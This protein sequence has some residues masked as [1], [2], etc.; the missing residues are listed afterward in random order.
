MI[1]ARANR[2]SMTRNVKVRAKTSKIKPKRQSA[3]Q[4]VRAQ[5]QKEILSP[6][7]FKGQNVRP[8]GRPLDIPNFYIQVFICMHSLLLINESHHG[9][10]HCILSSHVWQDLDFSPAYN[11]SVPPSICQYSELQPQNKTKQGR[12]LRN[13]SVRTNW[14]IWD[15]SEDFLT[16]L[17]I[18][19]RL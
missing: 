6:S 15:N 2:Q 11:H 12:I 13:K 5:V 18:W 7:T 8:Q 10:P 19:K 16:S 17:K 9:Y 3:G 4:N 1:E 14:S